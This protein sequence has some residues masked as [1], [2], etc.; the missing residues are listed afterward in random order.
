[1]K[2]K[3]DVAIRP[4]LKK[5]LKKETSFY[6]DDVFTLNKNCPYG[7]YL[8]AMFTTPQYGE[9]KP[10]PERMDKLTVEYQ[11]RMLATNKI[12][13]S[14]SGITS[15]NNFVDAIFRRLM[16]EAVKDIPRN[17]GNKEHSIKNGVLKFMGQYGISEDDFSLDA[18]LKL[19][20]RHDNDS[21]ESST[22]L[23]FQR[24]PNR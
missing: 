19:V 10:L 21:K 15:F 20:Q 18:A 1:M 9:C 14:Y 5:F 2:M 16:I 13:I 24:Q 6:K 22:A 11:A 12:E 17:R 8:F 7:A 3:I 4:Y 23:S